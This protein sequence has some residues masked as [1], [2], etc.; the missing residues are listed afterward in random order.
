MCQDVLGTVLCE[1]VFVNDYTHFGFHIQSNGNNGKS[2]VKTVTV[3]ISHAKCLWKEK[4]LNIEQFHHYNQ[5]NNHLSLQAIEHSKYYDMLFWKFLA[6]DSHINVAQ[7]N[8][9]MGP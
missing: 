4:G 6:W 7:L 8:Q 1:K 3:L 2:S 9:L 5:T